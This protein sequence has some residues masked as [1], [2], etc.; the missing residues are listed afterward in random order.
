MMDLLSLRSSR[1]VR[2]SKQHW[3]FRMEVWPETAS[4]KLYVHGM[5]ACV[6]PA[7]QSFCTIATNALAFIRVIL[8]YFSIK[9]QQN[10][11]IMFHIEK[12]VSVVVIDGVTLG[13]PCCG[14]PNC[15]VPLANNHNRFCPSHTHLN[16]ICAVVHC[17]LPAVIGRKTC[18]LSSHEAVENIHNDR[19]Q[20]RFQLKER[21][22]RAQL[23][24]LHDAF[25]VEAE[26]PNIS[27][28]V[29]D[30]NTEEEFQVGFNNGGQLIPI[31]EQ[32]TRKTT[33]CAQFGRKR[34]HNEQIFVA[35]C[36]IIVA[37]ETFY[38]AE[39][40]HSVIVSFQHFLTD[41]KLSQA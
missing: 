18:A 41:L 34:T 19:G 25:P 12:K 17:S 36:G 4:Q 10:I 26:N 15:K 14:E 20:A 16:Q 13:H 9:G 28:L 3:L 31:E 29:D 23:A 21:L 40:I 2:P 35:P 39:A 27:Q 11:I 1:T 33:L 8:F 30:D 38:H 37:R 5:S 6:S 24:H 22:R 32:S 7:S